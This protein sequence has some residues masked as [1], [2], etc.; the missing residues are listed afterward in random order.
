[1]IIF[2]IM[3]FIICLMTHYPHE[4]K[5][6]LRSSINTPR[7]G[8]PNSNQ[9]FSN[10][11]VVINKNLFSLH[12]VPQFPSPPTIT[13]ISNHLTIS[14]SI[15]ILSSSSP[16]SPSVEGWRFLLAVRVWVKNKSLRWGKSTINLPL[17]HFFTITSSVSALYLCLSISPLLPLIPSSQGWTCV[18]ALL[19][20]ACH[21]ARPIT[22]LL[23]L[24]LLL[25]CLDM[26]SRSL[27]AIVRLSL[28]VLR[29][30]SL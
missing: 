20:P 6:T 7:L 29:W 1:M 17:C 26:I 13:I 22:L 12:S 16:P 23:A 8:P 9:Y 15:F 10:F 24:S 25:F 28:S 14:Y 30:P 27:Q 21:P 19:P 18:M 3:P 5:P 11:L 2:G 4:T